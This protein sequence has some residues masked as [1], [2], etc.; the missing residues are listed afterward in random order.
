M[1]YFYIDDIDNNDE[2]KILSKK[3]VIKLIGIKRFS[4][5]F[6]IAKKDK[7]N[8]FNNTMK[9]FKNGILIFLF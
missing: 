5:W 9:D 7:E 6:N 2:F 1:K 8:G 3:Q 4:L